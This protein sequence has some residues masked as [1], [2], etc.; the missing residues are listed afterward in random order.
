MAHN[1]SK[2]R[3]EQLTPKEQENLW[4]KTY[5]TR[6]I[7]PNVTGVTLDNLFKTV[8]NETQYTTT[9]NSLGGDIPS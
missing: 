6:I 9:S 1:E 3:W 8:K 4:L 7:P 5:G 2:D